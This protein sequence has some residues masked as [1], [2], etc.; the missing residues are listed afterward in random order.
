MSGDLAQDVRYGFRMLLRN[1]GFT[2][3]AVLV[4]ALGIGATTAIFSLTDALLWKPLPVDK[5]PE[6]VWVFTTTPTNSHNTSSYL[7]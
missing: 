7:N 3:A 6:L 5:P 2:A 4:L 1:P